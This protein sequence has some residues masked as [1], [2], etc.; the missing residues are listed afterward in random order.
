[1]SGEARDLFA[2]FIPDGDVGRFAEDL[3]ARLRGDFTDTMTVLRESEFLKLCVDYPR[4]RT[5]LHRRHRRRRT[6]SSRSG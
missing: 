3:P 5:P 4:A 6:P 1:M 2:R